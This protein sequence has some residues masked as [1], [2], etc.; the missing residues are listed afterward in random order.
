MNDIGVVCYSAT[1]AQILILIARRTKL[2]GRNVA[3]KV[4]QERL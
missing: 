3:A 4:K 2:L 1:G